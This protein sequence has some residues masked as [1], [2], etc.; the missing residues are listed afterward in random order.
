MSAAAQNISLLRRLTVNTH[1]VMDEADFWEWADL[2]PI[3]IDATFGTDVEDSALMQQLMEREVLQR[4]PAEGC[5]RPECGNINGTRRYH[6]E[7]TPE[8]KML[9]ALKFGK[10]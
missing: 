9:R 1:G 2:A 6:F 8:W 7:F 10:A 5:R 3:T 4:H